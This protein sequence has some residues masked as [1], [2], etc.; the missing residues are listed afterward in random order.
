MR[1]YGFKFFFSILVVSCFIWSGALD[2]S[3]V[4]Q[5]YSVISLAKHIT[6]ILIFPLPNIEIYYTI[7]ALSTQVGKSKSKSSNKR[8]ANG[9]G[10][11]S[12]S[13]YK[14]GGGEGVLQKGPKKQKVA[15][16]N[17]NAK[18]GKNG[19]FQEENHQQNGYV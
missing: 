3:G 16:S 13:P 18:N 5:P 2:S 8:T 6:N 19:N 4:H 17:A 11:G 15:N 14:R 7:S 1:G 12:D 10:H 9:H